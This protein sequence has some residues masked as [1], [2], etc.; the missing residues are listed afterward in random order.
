MKSR[1][2]TEQD[3]GAAVHHLRE[4]LAVAAAEMRATRRL[5]RTWVFITVAVLLGL[6]TYMI[7]AGM[8]GLGS[9]VSATVGGFGP[10]MLVSSV[11]MPMVMVL[12]VGIIFLAFDI[13]A[14]DRRERM[15]EV[16]DARPVGTIK[17]LAGR[18]AGIVFILWLTVTLILGLMQTIGLLAGAFDW[19]FGDTMEPTS[20]LS[21]LVWDA[22]PTLMLWGSLVIF[23][24]VLLRNRLVVAIVALLAVSLWVWAGFETP[25]YLAPALQMSQAYVATGSD[26]LPEFANATLVVQRIAIVSLAVGLLGIAAALHPRRDGPTGTR[27]LIMGVALVGVAVAAIGYLVLDAA[28]GRSLRADWRAAHEAVESE[29]RVDVENI[30]GTIMVEPGRRLG[31]EVTYVVAAQRPLDGLTFSFNPGL[32]VSEILLDGTAAQWRHESGLLRVVL[33]RSLA[34]GER[35]ELRFVAAGIPDPSFAYLDSETDLDLAHGESGN[36]ILLGTDASVFDTRYVALMPGVSWLPL[37]GAATGRDDRQRYGRDYFTV[38]LEVG[39]PAGWLVAGPG[40]R[41]DAADGRFRFAPTAPVP[42]VALLASRFDRRAMEVDGVAFELL[43]HPGHGTNLD[44][45]ADAVGA[46][47]ERIAE[48]LAEASDA[49]IGYPYDGLSLVEIP[50][51]L[52]VYA[53]GWR[54]DS[55]QALPGVLMLREQGLPTA[56]FDTLFRLRSASTGGEYD[57]DREPGSAKIVA[58]EEFFDTDFSGGK[59]VDGVTRS[60]FAFQTGAHGPGAMALDYLCHELAAALIHRRQVGAY[61]SPRTFST[62]AGMNESIVPLFVGFLTGDF[63][64]TV[65][66]SAVPKAASVWTRTLGSPLITLDPT[67]AGHRT[68]DVLELKAPVLA[69]SIVDGLGREAA[70]ALLAELRR[71]HAGGNFSAADFEA[72]VGDAGVDLNGLLGNWLRDASLPGFLVSDA[73][74]VR[75]TDGARGEPRYQVRAHVRNGEPA[76]GLVRFG[77]LPKVKRDVS[78]Q[79]TD[80]VRI[81]AQASMELGLVVDGPPQEVWVSPYLSLNRGD[82]RLDAPEVDVTASVDAEPLNGAR[83]STWTPKPEPGIVV[84]DLDPGF[85]VVYATP[86]DEARYGPEATWLTGE[87]DIDEGLPVFKPLAVPTGGWMRIEQPATWGRYR[88]TVASTMS[89]GGGASV[90]FAAQLPSA[91]RWR[92]DYHIPEIESPRDLPFMEA[93]RTGI[94]SS[95]RGTY[96]MKI[97]TMDNDLPVEF[98]ADAARTGW[99]DLGEYSLPA[100]EVGLE[101]SN[102]T[103]G[104]IVIADAVRWRPVEER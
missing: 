81:G 102:K 16:L 32:E 2:V 44:V 8:H 43:L 65:A 31:L 30:R 73:Q 82:I 55:V 74:V 49:G 1:E 42:E 58:L 63:F 64:V 12:I 77:V 14:R 4:F 88:H 51:R 103:T 92:V 41:R 9:G 17:L 33:P 5:G 46:L 87:L 89:G 15:A 35:V 76:P 27:H 101:V 25:F 28:A 37:P 20:M 97:V 23:L 50:T 59:L 66:D 3:K 69:R 98:D 24:A 94:L 18:L 34:A 11:G 80:P 54:M 71:R 95:P 83:E 56:R 48:L 85:S 26:L 13:R 104:T 47:E 75:L 72:V 60:F 93:A 84:D 22:I 67:E 36:L 70:A 100:G 6:L 52:R 29:P 38:D 45:F 91:G 21:F 79:W 57:I 86:E 7:Y 40:R 10:R 62:S 96:E 61:F 39:V 19:W 53:G 99:N 68:L 90:R 78:T